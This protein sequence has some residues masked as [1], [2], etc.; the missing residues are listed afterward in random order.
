MTSAENRVSEPPNLKIF[1]GEDTP[2]TR[3]TWLVASPRALMP[4]PPPTPRYK[5]PSYGP[6][7]MS[8]MHGFKLTE[9]LNLTNKGISFLEW[10]ERL[11]LKQEKMVILLPWK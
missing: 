8:K 4:P 10:T 5:K 6:A 11:K 1:L 7:R 9:K 3:L 2:Q